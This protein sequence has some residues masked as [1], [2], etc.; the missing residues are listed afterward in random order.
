MGFHLESKQ[1][2]ALD[3]FGSYISGHGLC[4]EFNFFD[5]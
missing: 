5:I 4:V 2:M 3:R 1:Y